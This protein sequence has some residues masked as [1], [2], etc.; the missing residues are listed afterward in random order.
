MVAWILPIS[1][2]QCELVFPFFVEKPVML[3]VGFLLVLLVSVPTVNAQQPPRPNLVFILMDDLRFDELGCTGHPFVK[4]PNIDRLAKE[5]AIFKNAF[6]T[7]PLCSPS[8]ACFM[9]GLYAHTNGIFD[10]V[11]RSPQS[12]AMIT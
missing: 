3:R 2:N 4:T 9:S 11:D 7:T 8:R 12:H 1:D 6:A 10:N 5:G